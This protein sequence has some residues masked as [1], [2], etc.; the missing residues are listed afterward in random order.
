[1]WNKEER[2][3]KIQLEA[4]TLIEGD[5]NAS[6]EKEIHGEKKVD[7]DDYQGQVVN[8]EFSAANSDQIL[9]ADG[10]DV[11]HAP[12]KGQ[13]EFEAPQI[14][15]DEPALGNHFASSLGSPY[16]HIERHD[17]SSDSESDR[18]E[19]SSPD[20]SMAD[21]LPMLDELHP[22]LYSEHP[23]HAH[24]DINNS[25]AASQSSSDESESLDSRG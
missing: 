20:A 13:S 19:S 14:K 5:V 25:D 15:M 7:E 16:Q 12:S 8:R 2:S 24:K 23:Q 10:E 17:A 9:F 4:T 21:I 6:D 3:M 22:L 11:I 1:M 18:A